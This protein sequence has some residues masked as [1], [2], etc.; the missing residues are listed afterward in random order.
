MAKSTEEALNTA[1]EYEKRVRNVYR[2]AL[3]RSKNA[4]ARSLFEILAQEEQKHL[5]YLRALFKELRNAGKTSALRLKTG[6]PSAAT[7]KKSLDKIERG[8]ASNDRETELALL[9]R[10]LDAEEETVKLYEE[11]TKELPAKERESFQRFLEI[12]EGH[13]AI[14]QAQ[15]DYLSRTGYWFNFSEAALEEPD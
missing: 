5:N 15:I 2:E 7:L 4:E 10:A 11:M 3:E 12:E 14:V 9:K 8:V 1:P 13:L 6:L